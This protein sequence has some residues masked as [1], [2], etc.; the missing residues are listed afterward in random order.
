[1]SFDEAALAILK[2]STMYSRLLPQAQKS[3]NGPQRLKVQDVEELV[4]SLQA[5]SVLDYFIA[6]IE[7]RTQV[8]DRDSELNSHFEFLPI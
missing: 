5:K 2:E 4:E 6:A 8:L 7:R 3:L 1:M